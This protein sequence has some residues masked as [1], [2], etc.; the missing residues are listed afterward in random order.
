M[1]PVTNMRY[2]SAD[3]NNCKGITVKGMGEKVKLGLAIEKYSKGLKTWL[4]F[5]NDL[6][7]QNVFFNGK[8]QTFAS[9]N[10][11]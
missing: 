4:G 9:S 1:A 3:I 11:F 10:I 2:G 5:L 6:D 8:V 7:N